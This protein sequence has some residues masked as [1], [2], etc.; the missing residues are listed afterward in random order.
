MNV[1]YFKTATVNWFKNHKNEIKVGVKCLAIGLT[2]G[3]VEGICLESRMTAGLID[4]IPS[5]PEY[6]GVDPIEALEGL[7]P[8]DLREV[9]EACKEKLSEGA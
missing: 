2:I 9:I 1:S 8:D 6:D 4:K 5:A 7:E 3:F